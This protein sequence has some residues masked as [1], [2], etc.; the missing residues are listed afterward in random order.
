[1]NGTELKA[2]RLAHYLTQQQLA[3]K[4]DLGKRGAITISEW[5]SGK[6][7]IGKGYQLAIKLLF[8]K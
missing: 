2:L 7:E 4:L 3:E 8:D 6:R 1:M 5:E